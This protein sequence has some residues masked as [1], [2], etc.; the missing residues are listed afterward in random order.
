MRFPVRLLDVSLLGLAAPGFAQIRVLPPEALAPLAV[1]ALLL[2]TPAAP[3]PLLAASLSAQLQAVAALP[4]TAAAAVLAERAAA[5]APAVRAAALLA[6]A[7][8]DGPAADGRVRELAAAARR[9]PA[10][11]AWFDGAAGPPSPALEGLEMKRGRWRLAGKPLDRLGQGEFGFVDA[12]PSL[13][14][15]VIKTVEH[16]ASIQLLSSVSPKETAALEE[17]TARAIAAADAGP[18]HLGRARL[19]GRL[20]SAR[21]RVDGRTLEAL[22]R[23]KALGPDESALVLDLLRRLAAAGLKPDDMRPSNV[24]IGRTA[25]DPRRRAY[26]VDGGNLLAFPEGLPASDRAEHL[27]NAPI[28]LRGRFDMNMGWVEISK[29]M[30]LILEEGLERSSRTTFGRRFRG[31]WRDFLKALVP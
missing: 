18:R 27:L 26:L 16:S 15:V 24:M 10:L 25:L 3:A 5:P 22:A 4:P 23:E 30:R 7:R 11:A 21:E 19:R 9:D 8:L 6:A 17:K 12:H 2:G 1:P 14:G 28:M 29:P 13:P 20:V 31:F